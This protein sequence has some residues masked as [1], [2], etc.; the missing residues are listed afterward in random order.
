MKKIFNI[1]HKWIQKH[2]YISYSSFSK[3][4]KDWS[5]QDELTSLDK[6]FNKNDLT[7]AKELLNSIGVKTE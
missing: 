6:K 7:Q 5:I 2:E 1:K 3:I 4:I